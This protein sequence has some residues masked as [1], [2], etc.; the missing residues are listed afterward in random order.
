MQCNHMGKW[1][2][3]LMVHP[4]GCSLQNRVYGFFRFFGFFRI[5]FGFFSGFS[6]VYEDLIFILFYIIFM[7][8]KGF[9]HWIRGVVHSQISCTD[10]KS[11]KKFLYLLDFFLIFR[12][13]LRGVRGFFWVNNPSGTSQIFI[14]AVP[15]SQVNIMS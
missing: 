5:F 3:Y 14:I 2:F 4:S 15:L 13:F 6:W 9:K 7:N 10:F 11:S 12:I 1:E 8:K